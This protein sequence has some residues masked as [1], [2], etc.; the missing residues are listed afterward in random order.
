MKRERITIEEIYVAA[1]ANGIG[2]LNE[3]DVIVLETTV[4]NTI[5]SKL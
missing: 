1:R 5:I 4:D 2:N 3:I